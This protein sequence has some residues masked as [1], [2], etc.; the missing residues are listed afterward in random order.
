MRLTFT[1]ESDFRQ[2]RDFGQKISATFD[3]IGAHWQPLGRVL[4]YLVLPVAV[5]KNLMSVL[6]QLPHAGRPGSQAVGK[7]FGLQGF[8]M[9]TALTT[10]A[11]WLDSVLSS[12]LFTLLVISIYGYLTL[13]VRRRGPSPVVTV[14]E[15]WAVVRREFLSAFFSTWGLS[16]IVI[17][18]FVL[19]IV[20]GLYLSVA[21]SLFFMVKLTEGTGFSTTMS[22]CLSLIRGKWWSTFGLIM[23]MVLIF[24]VVIAGVGLAV[25][26]LSGGLQAILHAGQQQ[27]SSFSIAG[28][29]LNGMGLLLIYPPLLLVLAFQYFNLVERKDGV[30]LRQL[31]DTLGQGAAPQVHNAAYRPD[32]EGEY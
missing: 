6:F 12:V 18:G 20:P 11:S 28:V 32:E 24:Y 23:L 13:V 15:V 10:P 21:F 26:M 4:L 7:L 5:V 27:S 2:E 17:L 8:V 3:F 29:I 25:V 22:R 31:V 16:L 9:S 14:A 30:G 1:Q 19:G